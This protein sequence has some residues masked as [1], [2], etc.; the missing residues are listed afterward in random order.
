[1]TAAVTSSREASR[2]SIDWLAKEIA[3]KA[4]LM[5][6]GQTSY[7]GHII[8]C[9]E[10]I[11]DRLAAKPADEW[12]DISTAPKDG[13]EVILQVQLRAGIRGKCLV[14]HYMPGGFC[15]SDHPAIDAGWYFWNGCMFDKAAEP[16]KWMPLP[17]LSTTEETKR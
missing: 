3:E 9:A 14:G 2:P 17:P 7:L 8:K 6:T 16:T 13:R 1:M 11:Q 4:S 10:T 15:I 5:M 12:Q